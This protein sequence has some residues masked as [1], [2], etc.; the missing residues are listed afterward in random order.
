MASLLGTAMT[1]PQDLAAAG[2][3]PAVNQPPRGCFCK[4][5]AGFI[6]PVA[7][8]K[9]IPSN[10]FDCLV[11]IYPPNH[12]TQS[13]VKDRCRRGQ[14]TGRPVPFPSYVQVS[15]RENVER[16]LATCPSKFQPGRML[17]LATCPSQVP[18]SP[19]CRRNSI[20][21]EG[22]QQSVVPAA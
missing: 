10:G 22:T 17:R 5:H 8:S 21:V 3:S 11:R 7:Q 12:Q 16:G 1:D 20:Q 19:G 6:G 2:D 15:T 14:A 13:G 4:W 18:D 9:L